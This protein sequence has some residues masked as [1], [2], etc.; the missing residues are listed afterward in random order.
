MLLIYI[1]QLWK[2]G[3]MWVAGNIN[4]HESFTSVRFVDRL[5]RTKSRKLT[6]TC[7]DNVLILL[8]LGDTF[9]EFSSGKAN[10]I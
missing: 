9:Y 5:T 1:F 4:P 7:I 6:D 8:Y 2:G 3:W 10:T